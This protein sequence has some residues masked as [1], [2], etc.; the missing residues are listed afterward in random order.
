MAKASFLGVVRGLHQYFTHH[1]SAY[2][3]LKRHSNFFNMLDFQRSPFF[4][5]PCSLG[6][7]HSIQNLCSFVYNKNI[8]ADL[9]LRN[10]KHF[11]CFYRV[12]ET[13]VKVWEKREIVWDH[14]HEVRVFPRNF[15]FLPNFHKW[16]YK[17]YR[18][19]EKCFLFPLLNS[20]LKTIEKIN[21]LILI[22]F[23]LK[24]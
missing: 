10:R 23:I 1:G 4:Y 6:T 20:L 22:A 3:Q 14:E 7:I 5:T 12:I 8:R 13:R 21:L 24:Y 18:N 9:S 19:T 17:L 11:P 15:E 16:F 2:V